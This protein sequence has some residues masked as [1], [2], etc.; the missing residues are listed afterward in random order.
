MRNNR[1]LY[2]YQDLEKD[3]E[4]EFHPGCSTKIFGK[5]EPP[6]LDYTNDQ[7][8]ELA[9]K[10]IQSQSAVTGV[11]PKL[12]LGLEKLKNSYVPHK[13]T[14]TGVWGGYILK[15]PSEYYASLPELEDL[16]M[17]LAAAAGIE[18]V[19]HTLIRL[20]SGELSY[21]TK[22]IDREGK[23]K[24]HMEDMCQLT[25]KL[26]EAKYRG[27]YEQI[28]KALVEYSENPGL[29]I[30]NFF[31]Q[32]VFCFLTGNNDMH[33]KNFSL[34]KHPERGYNLSPA[35]DMVA[36]ELVVTGDDEELALT[37]NGK[38]KKIKRK[39]FEDAMERFNIDQQAFDNIFKRFT[40]ALPK[41]HMLVG[42][43][44]LPKEMQEEYRLM[45]DRKARQI[46][47]LK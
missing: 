20:Q 9:E 2:C 12:S 5:P 18:T 42:K 22:R 7:M 14:I 19:P 10:V 46:E 43:S 40:K 28:G 45:L 36:A 31:E 29:D 23:Q 16:T 38:K 4:S 33:L 47:I 17:H 37:L 8:L 25:E 44:F 35:Y 26:T 32:V 3:T 11:Q 30:I 13:L 41:W 15:P 1:C 34:F 6:L 27:S 21:L 24:F 39:D